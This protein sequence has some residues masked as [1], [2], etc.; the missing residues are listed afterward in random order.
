MQSAMEVDIPRL[1]Q[2]RSQACTQ[3]EELKV[4]LDKPFI[5]VDERFLGGLLGPGDP[6]Y[7][8]IGQDDVAD[9]V[10]QELVKHHS[11][12][13]DVPLMAAVYR[14]GDTTTT[15]DRVTFFRSIEVV[16]EH[17]KQVWAMVY[18]RS[19]PIDVAVEKFEELQALA[20]AGGGQLKERG[21]QW[22]S[23]P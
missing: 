3:L 7:V 14:P 11:E 2:V 21:Q 15:R 18:R 10:G 12:L 5:V 4:A 9:L 20:Q 22:P 19:T 23:W 1:Y 16:V 8:Q 6:F 17:K 13:I